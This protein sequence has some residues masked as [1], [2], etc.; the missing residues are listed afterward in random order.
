[1]TA[2][3]LEAMVVG[4]MFVLGILLAVNLWVRRGMLRILREHYPRKWKALGSPSPVLNNSVENGIATIRFIWSK[5]SDDADDADLKKRILV[6][7]VLHVVQAAV[8]LS[9]LGIILTFLASR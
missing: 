4:V 7:R 9:A 8:L 3:S 1:M 5:Q 6:E 2:E